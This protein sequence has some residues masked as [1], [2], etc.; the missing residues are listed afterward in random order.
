[1]DGTIISTTT[2]TNTTSTAQSQINNSTSPYI[3]RQSNTTDLANITKKAAENITV[4]P[5]VL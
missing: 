3:E 5:V 2:S 1:M 4:E